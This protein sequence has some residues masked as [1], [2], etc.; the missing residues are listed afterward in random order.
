VGSCWFR[1]SW[2]AAFLPTRRHRYNVAMDENPYKSPTPWTKETPSV[3]EP[4]NQKQLHYLIAAAVGIIAGC[5]MAGTAV[6]IILLPFPSV[7]RSA[8]AA[9]L[10]ALGCFNIWNS[11]RYLR[12][13]LPKN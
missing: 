7:S 2:R 13:H 9:F 11:I 8:T 1:R 10:G 6:F 3:K 5:F 12:R 4:M